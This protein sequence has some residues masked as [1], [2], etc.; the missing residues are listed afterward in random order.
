[1]IHPPE[2]SESEEKEKEDPASWR[3]SPSTRP[4]ILPAVISKGLISAKIS[5]QTLTPIGLLLGKLFN[6]MLKGKGCCLSQ[7]LICTW[8][9]NIF[10]NKATLG[11]LNGDFLP[12]QLYNSEEFDCQRNWVKP[13][14]SWG[15]NMRP[16]DLLGCWIPISYI[17]WLSYCEG[18]KKD[19]K[20]WSNQVLARSEHFEIMKRPVKKK[21][22]LSPSVVLPQGR[23]RGTNGCM[24]PGLVKRGGPRAPGNWVRNS[25]YR[26]F[27][28][29]HYVQVPG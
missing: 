23:G 14:F 2:S 15:F 17:Q 25:S 27:K 28:A 4:G 26:F 8:N 7:P 18:A 9:V 29:D 12:S 3:C 19:G 24:P 5:Q 22:V 10:Y 21:V 6:V 16:G 13:K 20:S 1:M 11:F